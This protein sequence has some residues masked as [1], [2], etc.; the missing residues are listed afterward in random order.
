VFAPTAIFSPAAG[1]SGRFLSV[2]CLQLPLLRLA[3]LLPNSQHIA[4]SLFSV[5]FE[6]ALDDRS[7]AR[8]YPESPD[9]APGYT[10][11]MRIVGVCSALSALAAICEHTAF[12]VAARVHARLATTKVALAMPAAETGHESGKGGG[13]SSSFYLEDLVSQQRQEAEVEA[14]LEASVAGEGFL[15]CYR[16]VI[17]DLIFDAEVCF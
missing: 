7:D 12:S 16:G 3:E 17:Q 6:E 15:A 4:L 10:A 9:A 1:C 8:E 2:I 14:A 11:S 13:A 5:F